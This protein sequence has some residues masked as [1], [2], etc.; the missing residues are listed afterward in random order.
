MITYDDVKSLASDQPVVM[1]DMAGNAELRSALH[2]H[3]GD[4]MKYSCSIGATHWNATGG[5]DDL[6]GAKPEFFFAPSQIAKRSQQWGPAEL[7]KRI[8]EAWAE[9][10]DS[11][12][13]WLEVERGYGR[14]AVERVFRATL[15][16]KTQPAQ[17]HVISLWDSE[18]EAAGS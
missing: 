16:A 10:R 14:E 1:V 2:H 13:A 3:F 5:S 6:P 4:Q 7:Q 8:G 15:D 12:D 9:F 18:R 17:G 11:S